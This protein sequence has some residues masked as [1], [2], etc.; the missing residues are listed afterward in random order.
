MRSF[1]MC[2]LF[3]VS[4]PAWCESIV[5]VL[6][7]SSE[8]RLQARTPADPGSARAAMVQ[9]SWQRL[10]P[11][12]ELP[13]L[14]EL[15][16]VRGELYAEAL[17]GRRVVASEALAELPEGERVLMLAH[18]LGHI[19]L[20]HW[21]AQ[22]ALYKRFVPGEVRPDT[23]DPV[24]AALGAQAHAQ[25]HRHEYE[26]DAYGYALATRLGYGM[27]SAYSLMMRLASPMD[28]ATHPGT[29]RR[30]AQLREIDARQDRAGL[31]AALG[32]E[33]LPPGR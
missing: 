14:P 15:T 30:V 1:W 20:G 4:T 28:T 33:A 12:T 17:Q 22:C 11:L 21:E 10:Q 16:L 31:S 3:L 23:T 7:R 2:A 26:A 5:D 9:A 32:D 18:E 25:S 24:A 8:M 29:R 6:V 13:A 27:D 19:A